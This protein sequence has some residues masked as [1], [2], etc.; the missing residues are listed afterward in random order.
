MQRD[1]GRERAL[2]TGCSSS[3]VLIRAS[4]HKEEPHSLSFLEPDFST[5]VLFNF[6]NSASTSA[7]F[8]LSVARSLLSSKIAE[9]A[10]EEPPERQE[11]GVLGMLLREL[12]GRNGDPAMDMGREK[13]RDERPPMDELP[14]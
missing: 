14:P 11:R 6:A 9:D 13:D 8:F 3:W 4:Q 10:A 2:P 1:R 7:R 5:R 12:S